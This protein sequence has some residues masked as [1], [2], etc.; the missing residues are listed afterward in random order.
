MHALFAETALLPETG[1][2]KNVRVTVNEAGWIETVEAGSTPFASDEILRDCLLLPAPANLHSHAFQRAMA[3][4][5]ETRGQGESDSFWTWRALMYRFLQTLDP[6][7]VEAIAAM[8]YVE[9]LEAGYAAV[10]EFHYLHHAPDGRHYANIAEM[11]TRIAAAAHA[12]GIGMTL[13]PVLYCQGGIDGRPLSGGQA[14]FGCDMAHF[15]NLFERASEA[16]SMLADDSTV[17]IAP[18]SLRAVPQDV[19]K[20]AVALQFGPIHIHIAEQ[21]AEVE[22]IEAATGSRPVR[23]LLDS[24]PVD[25]R[26]C[27]IHATHMT[28][29]ETDDLARSGAVAGLCPITEANLGDGIFD[30]R[31]FIEA[32]GR[33]GI[34]SDSNV[35]IALAEEL[36]TLEYSQRYRDRAR[37]VLAEDG[38]ST[39]RSLY[40]AALAGGAQALG[41]QSGRLAPDFHADMVAV[42]VD[43]FALTDTIGDAGLDGWIFAGDDRAV[44][45][46]WSAGRPVVRDG[47]HRD[48]STIEARY[49][50]VLN[51]LREVM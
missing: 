9:M 19:L 30:G 12:T 25:A 26:W 36:R 46:V 40:E 2:A 6:D 39:G 49:R 16:M 32:D 34:G 10:G 18:H 28:A 4:M 11:S 17:G 38:L 37:I 20:D 27:A 43:G 7:Q 14:R 42:D 48:R 8:V 31:R 15:A 5:G 22:E 24:L 23:R 33:F 51:E 1:W 29:E 45:H 44:R 21:V 35:R 13:L 3:G 41:R 47:R 50:H